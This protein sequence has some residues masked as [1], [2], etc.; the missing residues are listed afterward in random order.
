[1]GEKSNR[2]SSIG[3]HELE[4]QQG[5]EEVE[6]VP[7][8]RRSKRKVVLPARYKDGNFVSLHSSFLD[9]PID[10][11]VLSSFNEAIGVKEWDDDM[12]DVMNALIRNQTWDL[13]PKPKEVKLITCK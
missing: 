1:M 10:E 5:D 13:V 4:G 8:L 12:N 2:G 3:G 11:C 7:P 6:N 9:N